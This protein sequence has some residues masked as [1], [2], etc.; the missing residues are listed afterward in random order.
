MNFINEKF[1]NNI[2]MFIKFRDDIIN[3]LD[4]EALAFVDLYHKHKEGQHIFI[5][6]RW[7]IFIFLIGAVLC[8]TFSSIYHLFF[9]HSERIWKLLAKFD[10]AGISILIASSCFPHYYYI[11][12][13]EKGK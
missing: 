5:L 11:F 9:L 10:Y 4:S 13:C 3:K 12:Y 7:P 6:S 8:L 1:N 2:D